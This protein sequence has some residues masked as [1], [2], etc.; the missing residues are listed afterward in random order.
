MSKKGFSH[1]N[2]KLIQSLV[3]AAGA[4]RI[5][6]F[7]ESP[8]KMRLSQ[9]WI[10]A[11][12]S[13]LLLCLVQPVLAQP[14]PE[15]A[16]S[17]PVAGSEDEVSADYAAPHQFGGPSSVAGQLKSDHS[18]QVTPY[19]FGGLTAKAQPYYDFKKGVADRHAFAFG[20]D[21]TPWCRVRMRVSVRMMLR[22]ASYVFMAPGPRWAG[23][24]RIPAH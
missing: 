20:A 24:R 16:D 6:I 9:N 13:S 17:K 7:A 19:W 12:A 18:A 5:P 23:V 10:F 4:P 1:E 14:D 3:H 8:K 11:L 22:A 15:A 21:T 2:S